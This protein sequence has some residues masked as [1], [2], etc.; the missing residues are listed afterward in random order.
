MINHKYPC[1][2]CAGRYL[3]KSV[4]VEDRCKFAHA[5]RKQCL[6]LDNQKRLDAKYSKFN[7]GGAWK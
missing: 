7:D 1:V 5:S 3:Y 4:A 2:Y 6:D